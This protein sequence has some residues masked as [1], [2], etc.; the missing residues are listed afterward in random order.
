MEKDQV[1]TI[2]D[3]I[4]VL[5][6]LQGETGFRT[7]AY[8][9]A[10]R[11]IA[12]LETPLAEIIAAGTLTDIF[13]IGAAMKDKIVTLV[14]TGSLPLHEELKA[15]TPPGLFTLLRLPGLG[16]KK[17]KALH[18]QLGIQNLEELKE[19]CETGKVAV[20]RGFGEKTQQ[21]ILDGMAFLS[22][23]GE[24][25]RLDQA[26]A[27]AEMLVAELR[28]LPSVQRLEVC[29]SVRRRKEVIK[30][31]DL[32]ISSPEPGPIME[33][34][35]RLPQVAQV[36]GQGDTKSS[37]LVATV[38]GRRIFL[39][40][41]LR[42]VSDEQFPFAL[43]YFTGSKEHN[44]AMRQR[45]I[46]RSLRLNEYELSGPDRR[47]S[48]KEEA[49]IYHAL[50]LDYVPPELRE[51]TG[52]I[53]AAAAHRL[54]HLVEHGDLQGVFHCHTT[55]SDGRA[56]LEQ[57]AEGA[58]SLGF[59]Y[60]G[61]ADHSQVMKFANGLT[62]ERVAEQHAE[63]D[64]LNAR[65]DGFRLFKGTECD[66]LAD[67]TLDYADEVL[68]RFDYVV[69]SVHSNFNQTPEEMTQRIVRAVSHPRVT[70][71]GHATGR[72][73]LRRDGYK[74]DLEAVLQAAA[75]HGTMIEINAQPDRL[76]LD[77]LHC[78]RAKS[79]GVKLVINPDAHSV[80]ELTF[81]EYG[82]HVARRGWLEKGDVFNTLGLD[83]VTATLAARKKEAGE[84][85]RA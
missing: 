68:A 55:Y 26:L 46:Q 37:A 80:G 13:G 78:K 82:I 44:I 28:A 74:V 61:I 58:R 45:A 41:D 32:L 34:F 56:T 53:D 67:G 57:M 42:V 63:I 14:T 12:Q 7:Q 2:L 73:L 4:G 79:L 51:Q 1:A 43:N 5:L 84:R 19:A 23:V 3:E 11:A 60:L 69:A 75:Q 66:I 20:L 33:A 54:P 81:T 39:Q 49:D 21:K 40:A 24:R 10:A 27:L 77:W 76:D 38:D 64:A 25:V 70:M 9:R 15:K 59:R 47:V 30:D 52:E 83:D 50:D 71:L 16:P 36:L 72:L 62:P 29:G 31:I 22:Q 85:L 48:C 65:L 18:D 35:V 17:I 6:E 8:Y